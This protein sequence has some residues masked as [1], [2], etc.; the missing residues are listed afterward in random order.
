[1]ITYELYRNMLLSLIKEVQDIVPGDVS[2]VDET[3]EDLQTTTIGVYPGPI[4]YEP[5]EL[6]NRDDT[7]VLSWWF[8]VYANTPMQR[9]YLALLL[10]NKLK[11]WVIR[12][13]DFSAGEAL[14][15][16]LYIKDT[17]AV[18]PQRA[19]RE[20]IDKLRY[21]EIIS[22]QSTFQEA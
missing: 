14:L 8:G 20:H 6:G 1:M 15:G 10:Y 19:P 12:V 18:N 22:F 13:L 7:D 4:R 9:D 17:V 21:F 5:Y 16:R 11:D 3:E 2:V